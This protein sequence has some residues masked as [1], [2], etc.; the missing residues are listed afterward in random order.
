M[1]GTMQVPDI[2]FQGYRLSSD[3]ALCAGDLSFS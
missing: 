1:V 2:G 3:K